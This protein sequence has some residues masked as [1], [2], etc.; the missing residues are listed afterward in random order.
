M[1]YSP[2]TTRNAVYYGL[3]PHLPFTVRRAVRRWFALR[4]RREAGNV[5]PILPG[6][7]QPPPGWPGWPNGKKFALVLSHDVERQEGVDRCRKLMELEMKWGFR[8]CFNF[9]PEGEYQVPKDLR[10]ELTGNGFEVGV[11]DLHHDGKLYSG[12]KNFQESAAKI[13]RYAEEWGAEGFRSGFMFHNLE[14]FHDLKVKYDAS[15]FDTDPF[16]PQPDGVET[17][18]PFWRGN[19][20]GGGYAE[21][22]YTLPQDFTLFLLF[23]ETTPEIWLRK[24]DWVAGHGGMVMVIVHPDYIQFPGDPPSPRTFPVAH[25]ERLLE[26][27][28]DQYQ[29]T[30]W[31]VLP[32]EVAK[33]VAAH[34]VEQRVAAP[35][36]AGPSGARQT[37]W[38]DLDNTPHVPLFKPIAAELEKRGY[39][40]TLTARDAFQV[41][42]LAAKM[43]LNYRKIGRHSGKNKLRKIIGL[44]VRAAQLAPVI[45]REKP[46][47]A[48]SHGS[49]AQIIICN[50]L[51]IPTLL[52]ADYEFAAYP[53]FMRPTWEMA[54]DIIPDSALSCPPDK[55]KKYPG[56][57][58][59]IYVPSFQPDDKLLQ[60]LALNADDIIAVVR[61]PATEAHYHNPDAEPLLAHFMARSHASPGVKVILVPRNKRQGDQ[62]RADFPAWFE[63]G[64]TVIPQTAVDGLNLI[65]HADLVLSGGG[66]MNREAAAL[67]VPVYSVFRGKIGAVDRQLEKEGR[68]KL[69]ET[70][71]DVD[72]IEFVRRTRSAAGAL[73]S[74]RALATVV[75]HI[76]DVVAWRN[77]G[78]RHGISTP[79]PL[80]SKP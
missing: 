76:I 51:G 53:P 59:D 44:F 34:R 15:T 27:A 66:T 43:G 39:D 20:D 72:K 40:V 71:A 77:H 7:E 32:K 36:A 6:S 25:Y 75:N 80:E 73:G 63:G 38:I 58:E 1:D 78:A 47:L 23:Q 48:L 18:F 45:W 17:I 5:W 50:L 22:P 29:D 69:L 21:L 9:V 24:L 19:A 11:H 54:P 65:W 46:V 68:L 64:R 49:R 2:P 30:S 28:R 42:E 67:G 61:P 56:I 70:S 10:D 60:E 57:K 13:N 52:M 26:Y 31:A 79:Q 37:V 4:K 12:R 8:S 14:W 35:A 62:L 41:C 74:R 55:V 16:E 3:K 33:F